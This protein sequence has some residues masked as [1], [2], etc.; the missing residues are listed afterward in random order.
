MS[1]PNITEKK[2]AISACHCEGTQNR[3]FRSSAIKRGEQ[4]PPAAWLT[5]NEASALPPP[6]F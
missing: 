6:P 1:E 4:S 3:V 2:P 5:V